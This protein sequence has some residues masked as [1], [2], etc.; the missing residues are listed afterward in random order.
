[1]AGEGAAQVAAARRGFLSDVLLACPS[2][3]VPH[4]PVQPS[5]PVPKTLLY[6]SKVAAL[7]QSP[8]PFSRAALHPGPGDP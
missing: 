8:P 3:S 4:S 1:M 7:P 6:F 5:I 2:F